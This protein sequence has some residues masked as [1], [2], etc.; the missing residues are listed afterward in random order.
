MNTRRWLWALVPV[1]ASACGDAGELDTQETAT[2]S[3][4]ALLAAKP[5]LFRYRA[6]GAAG[7]EMRYAAEL[8]QE[9]GTTVLLRLEGCLDERAVRELFGV[10]RSAIAERTDVVIDAAAPMIACPD[11]IAPDANVYAEPRTQGLSRLEYRLDGEPPEAG[12][13]RYLVIPNRC[14]GLMKHL[15]IAERARRAP[16]PPLGSPGW[17]PEPGATPI[18]LSCANERATEPY[19]GW[20]V[21]SAWLPSVEFRWMLL[22]KKGDTSFF[23]ESLDGRPYNDLTDAER[24]RGLA[25]LRTLLAVPSS[26]QSTDVVPEDAEIEPDMPFFDVCLDRCG[27]A[28]WIPAHKVLRDGYLECESGA[29]DPGTGGCLDGARRGYTE[30][31]ELD[32]T[33]SRRAP[34]GGV[35]LDLPLCTAGETWERRFGLSGHD[36]GGTWLARLIS[37][38]NAGKGEGAAPRSVSLPCLVPDRTCSVTLRD[39]TDLSTTTVA[40]LT[41]SCAVDAEALE[42]RVGKRATVSRP[43]F[44]LDAAAFPARM[45]RVRMVGEPEGSLITVAQPTCGFGTSTA[46]TEAQPALQVNGDM[47]VDL[48]HLR[49]VSRAPTGSTSGPPA[50]LARVGVHAAGS[51]A[52]GL[53]LRLRDVDIGGDTAPVFYKGIVFS[54]GTLALHSSSVRAFTDGVSADRARVSIVSWPVAGVHSIESLAQPGLTANDLVDLRGEWL[55]GS[56]ANFR[57]L[58]LSADVQAFVVGMRVSGPMAVAWSDDR[59][60]WTEDG[61][62]AVDSTFT[63]APGYFDRESVML[64]VA[65][66]GQL[67]FV[68]TRVADFGHVLRCPSRLSGGTAR[69]I[70]DR[71]EFDEITYGLRQGACTV[72]S[73]TLW[74]PTGE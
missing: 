4:Q 45:R 29:L 58:T 42:V 56:V 11:R 36:G 26:W 72:E 47:T 3:A 27:A 49:L 25:A 61:L 19:D 14:G 5:T 1:V 44:T 67:N 23:V 33:T 60:T 17:T 46:C 55:G 51:A 62:L 32:G 64:S 2:T 59:A 63:S 20:E 24:E 74:D 71:P 38:Y 18:Q 41:R 6:I 65:G 35:I 50:P 16:A 15:G 8:P 39:S 53:V 40:T 68:N 10:R 30:R 48:E 13:G 66:R 9:D 43:P 7:S 22:V 70:F 69:I 28:G 57:A 54:G 34:L 73:A 31:L 52:R 21:H 12:P 37:A